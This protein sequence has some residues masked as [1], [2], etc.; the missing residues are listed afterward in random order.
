MGIEQP[1]TSDR[2]TNL[3]KKQIKQAKE[4]L[5]EFAD[6]ITGY[7]GTITEESSDEIKKQ[8]DSY[9]KTTNTE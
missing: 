7:I 4:N 6:E 2:K 5:R 8:V 3:D 9:F 1:E